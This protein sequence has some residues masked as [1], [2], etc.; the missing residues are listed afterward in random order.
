MTF[1]LKDSLGGSTFTSIVATITPKEEHAQETLSTLHFAQRA[2]SVKNVVTRNVTIENT[3]SGLRKEI[4]TLKRMMSES[5]MKKHKPSPVHSLQSLHGRAGEVGVAGKEEDMAEGKEGGD[6]TLQELAVVKLNLNQELKK[7]AQLKSMQLEMEQKMNAVMEEQ[8]VLRE[9]AQAREQ[10]RGGGGGGDG[11]KELL[12]TFLTLVSD[13]SCS[14]SFVWEIHLLG[15]YLLGK[16][17]WENHCG[18]TIV[19]S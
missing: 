9:K 5:A 6:C 10:V 13:V 19:G 11:G 15:I 16:P 17:L 18:N 4:R 14:S 1:L 3:V 7:S 8:R 12:K 2:K